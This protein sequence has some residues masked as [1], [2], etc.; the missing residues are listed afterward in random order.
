MND[1]ENI[2]VVSDVDGVLTD[3]TFLYDVN[4]KQYKQFGKDDADAIKLMRKVMP[5]SKITFV[6]SDA[7]GFDIS[8]KRVADMGCELEFVSVADR[9]AYMENFKAKNPDYKIAYIGDSFVDLPVW[10][11]ADIKYCVGHD[12]ETFMS[13]YE[14]EKELDITMT[15]KQGGHS[16]FAEALLGIVSYETGKRIDNLVKEYVGA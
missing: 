15:N 7:H 16:G 5:G 14:L 2:F 12:I 6:S 1:I 10:D 9:P 8:K 4:G 3:G 11:H 13:T